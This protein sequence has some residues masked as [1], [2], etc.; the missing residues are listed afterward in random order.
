MRSIKVLVVEDFDPIRRFVCSTLQQR[1]GFHIAQASDGLVAVQEIEQLKPDLI[2]LDVGLPNLSGIEVAKCARRL[3]PA[4]KILFLSV[5]SDPDVIRQALSVGA[6]GYIHKSRIRSDLLPAIDAVL[7][8]KRFVSRNFRQ[9][10]GIQLPCRHEILFSSDNEVLQ[11]G[12]ATFI[13]AALSEGDAAIVWAN[14]PHRDDL[15]A[16]LRARGVDVDAVIQNGTYIA[17]DAF[18]TADPAHILATIER[19]IDAASRAGKERPRVA[20]CGERA[21]RL[22]ADG[23]TDQ[24]LCL[25]QMFNQLAEGRDDIDLLCVYPLPHGYD[26]GSSVLSLCAEHSG[27]FYL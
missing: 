5:E 2:L 23:K 21:G 19:L 14:E 9:G 24:A 8:G 20:V 16:R 3:A 10:T 26:P 7:G 6:L 18:E 13:T 11:D 17:A 4:A 22:W 25:E 15:L 1:A 12:L 27:V